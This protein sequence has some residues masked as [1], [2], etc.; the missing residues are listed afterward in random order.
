MPGNLTREEL[1]LAEPLVSSFF[2]DETAARNSHHFAV[3]LGPF[4]VRA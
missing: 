3:K 2:L 4:A 1:F